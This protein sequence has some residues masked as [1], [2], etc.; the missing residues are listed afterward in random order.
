MKSLTKITLIAAAFLSG[1][2]SAQVIIGD[3]VAGA[4]FDQSEALALRSLSAARTDK[5]LTHG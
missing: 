3:A 5:E 1:G 4:N 2:A